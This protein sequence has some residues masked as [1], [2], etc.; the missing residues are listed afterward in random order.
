MEKPKSS[1]CLSSSGTFAAVPLSDPDLSSHCGSLESAGFLSEHNE[2]SGCLPEMTKPEP[3]QLVTLPKLGLS[4]PRYMASE[5]LEQEV[6]PSD[7]NSPA[8]GSGLER[9]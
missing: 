6:T 7:S 3:R 4:P 9:A 8:N 5:Y 2:T 1:H